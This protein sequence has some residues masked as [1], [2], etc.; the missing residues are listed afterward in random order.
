M[1]TGIITFHSANNCGSML[2]S[3]ALQQQLDRLGFDNEIID[4]ANAAQKHM[5]ALLRKPKNSHDVKYDL[6]ALAYYSRFRTHYYDYRKF[7]SEKLRLSSNSYE[8]SNELAETNQLYG[9]FVAGSDQVWNICCTDADDAYFLNFV[10][11]EKI[12]IAYAPSFGSTK[13]SDHPEKMDKYTKYLNRFD[14]LSIRENNGAAWIK[15]MTGR[16]APVLIDPTMFLSKSD[17]MV[18]ADEEKPIDEKYIFYY[19]FNYAD[20]VNEVVKKISES[21]HMPVY[22]M[23]AK[24][25]VKNCKKF[26]FRLTK[27]SGPITFLNMLLNAELVLTT[28][29]HGTVFSIIGEKKFCF[30]NSSMHND[31]DDRTSTLLTMFNL[32]DHFVDCSTIENNENFN[33]II[34]DEWDFNDAKSLLDAQRKKAVN[35]LSD[36]FNHEKEEK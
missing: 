4:F 33:R 9:A 12:K 10:D 34:C 26:N 13:I 31:R 28:S 30:L 2:Q 5:Y 27:N 3:Y 7:L 35:Y 15:E 25:W 23:D 29:F 11:D 16:T 6:A 14:F 20:S 21:L 8:N 22:V 19:A 24:G 32:M 1:K 36:A 18:L 17:Y